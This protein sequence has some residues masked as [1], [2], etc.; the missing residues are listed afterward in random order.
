MRAAAWEAAALAACVSIAMYASTLHGAFTYDDKVAVVGNQ[1]VVQQRPLRD[2]FAHDFWGNDIVPQRNHSWTHHS[3]RPLV[4][5]SFQLNWWMGQGAV[6]P[7]HVTNMLL[8]AACCAIAALLIFRL[9]PGSTLLPT[10]ASLLFATCPVHS[11][12]VANITSRA[13]TACGV[14]FLAGLL[15]QVHWL[16]HSA[17]L[18]ALAWLITCTL[19]AVLCKETA[20]VLPLIGAVLF[21]LLPNGP[22]GI[23]APAKQ[24]GRAHVPLA[25]AVLASARWAYAAAATAAGIAIYIL[26]I[27]VLSGGY[28]LRAPPVH[29]P[30][31]EL[32][33][34]PKFLS[35][36]FVQAL[37]LS[38]TVFPTFLSH[39]HN[40]MQPVSSLLDWR[41]L[42]TLAAWVCVCW[43]G[44]WTATAALS[45]LQHAEDGA[46]GKPPKSTAKHLL[47]SLETEVAGMLHQGQQQLVQKHMDQ[48]TA[49]RLATGLAILF[50]AYL[51]SSHLFIKVGFVLAE[52]TLFLPSL[53]S[54]II[55]AEFLLLACSHCCALGRTGSK[56]PPA[57]PGRPAVY[58]LLAALSV[59]L[60]HRFAL[61]QHRNTEWGTEEALL[62]SC[63]RHYPKDNFMS[64]YGLGADYLYK[65][66]LQEAEKLLLEAGKTPGIAEPHVLLSQLYWRHKDFAGPNAIPR[67]MKELR[68]VAATGRKRE[69][70]GN[71]GL[72]GKGLQATHPQAMPANESEYFVL[73][74]HAAHALPPR[75][76]L[77]GALAHNAACVRLTSPTER[78]GH[79][80]LARQ[81][82]QEAVGSQ[83]PNRHVA[84]HNMAV[85]HAIHGHAQTALAYL[86]AAVESVGTD[87]AAVQ[88]YLKEQRALTAIKAQTIMS[89]WQ[90]SGQRVVGPAAQA[91]MGELGVACVSTLLWF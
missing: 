9:M 29:N 91:R 68:K 22:D 87:E 59:L 41:N 82:L 21:V 3:Y 83:Y 84:L 42:A 6:E 20:L 79:H 19:L 30:L 63:L 76:P 80:D 5:L 40:A 52:R 26:R 46:D 33:A 78:W 13:E 49:L 45:D 57:R 43:L 27:R 36:A 7:F 75:S 65:G 50:I 16:A 23:S 86:Q 4:V 89:K 70:L 85:F 62:L 38:M 17:P 24:R 60:T 35:L 56:Q 71:L 66:R 11:E 48:H 73:A 64:T 81:L 72:L 55:A 15:G 54:S 58:W 37:G 10:L 31:V 61:V 34:W 14:F 28:V 1:D 53:G 77:L 44:L 47:Q 2:V 39:E 74:A 8:H 67:A 90:A 32:E 18:K 88:L 69:F 12:V 25:K 51:P